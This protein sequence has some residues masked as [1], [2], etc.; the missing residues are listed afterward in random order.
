MYSNSKTLPPEFRRSL[1]Q[2]ELKQYP[3]SSSS[4]SGFHDN[5]Q[6]GP[7]PD[8]Q[9]QIEK[10]SHRPPS[11][12]H[13]PKT[14]PPN[15]VNVQEQDGALPKRENQNHN[16]WVFQWNNATIAIALISLG[17]AGFFCLLDL[18]IIYKNL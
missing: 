12:G 8:N 11:A 16:D 3:S 6:F 13:Q 7:S 18:Y 14:Q 17:M 15:R 2:P 9:D 5:V 4:G 1:S 10:R